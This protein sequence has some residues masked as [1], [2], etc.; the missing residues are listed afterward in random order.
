MLSCLR[1]PF[2]MLAVMVPVVAWSQSGLDLVASTAAGD[3]LVE[4][5]ALV[6]DDPDPLFTGRW[7]GVPGGLAVFQLQRTAEPRGED[8]VMLDRVVLSGMG[9]YL[10]AHI[11]FTKLGAVAD[12]PVE[13]MV[14]ELNAMIAAAAEELGSGPVVLGD[15]TVE[16]LA[17]L[18]G[19]DWRSA[20]ERNSPDDEKY[21]A[22]YHVVQSQRSE[23][24]RQ[25]KAD[26]LPLADVL[27][28][29]VAGA[30]P[31][32]ALRIASTCGTVFDDQNF[33][34]ALD[35]QLADTGAGGIDPELG[36]QI[37]QA[38][39]APPPTVEAAED[40]P[41]VR[42]RDRWLKTELDAINQRID[43]MD[44]RKELWQ[45]RDRME[46]LEDRMTGMQL[47]LMDVQAKA[48]PV[49]ENPLASLSELTRGNIT[50]RFARN[51]AVLDREHRILLNEV[52]EQ[53]ARA[54]EHRIL[55]TGFTDR[56]GDPMTNLHLSE[57]RAKAVRTYLLERG[58]GADRL[59]VNHYGDSRSVGR[60]PDERRVEVEWL[61]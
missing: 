26:L 37:M 12:V 18:A 39:A 8:R 48:T 10:D 43:A 38:I 1:Y 31:G 42:K 16:R 25:L 36:R 61:P 24:E 56:S 33:L 23:L 57:R 51:S 20:M 22:I 54:S 3:I 14:V 30:S 9:A 47:E 34:C 58:I 41:K 59:L 13:R 27:V 15:P 28:W 60:D 35:L 6:A 2:A 21:L 45:L 49:E 46:D 53:L 5:R 7:R 4:A 44:Q 19:L 50:I 11:R 40:M 17:G 55:I 29:G 52:F 32:N